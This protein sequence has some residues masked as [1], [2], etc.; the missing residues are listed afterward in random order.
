MELDIEEFKHNWGDKEIPSE[1]ERLIDFQENVSGF[2]YYSDGFGVREEKREWFHGW[3]NS[4]DFLNRIYPFAKANGSGSTYAIWDDGS[5]KPMAEMP[6]IVLGDEGGTHI[7][8]EN[9]RQLLHLLTFDCEISVDWDSA[10]VYKDTDDYEENDDL[11]EFLAWLKDEYN[12]VPIQTND[13]ANQ[14]IASAQEKYKQAF[15]NWLGKYCCME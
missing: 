1:L 7:V 4:P 11:P 3:S 9:M 2:E 13:E 8:A 15:D 5:T 6:I 10:F 12:I 14:L